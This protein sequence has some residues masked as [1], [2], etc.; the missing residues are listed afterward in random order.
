M[1]T[2][3]KIILVSIT[4]AVL[5]ILFYPV[6]RKPNLDGNW[7][8]DKLV[9]DDKVSRHEGTLT[10]SNNLVTIYRSN[11]LSGLI[12]GKLSFKDDSLLVKIDKIINPLS[13]KQID[14]SGKYKIDISKD[15]EGSG[16]RSVFVYQVT[17][18]SNNKKIILSRTRNVRWKKRAQRGMP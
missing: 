17:L 14:F 1:G 2:T 6:K 11:Y 12:T 15:V 3:K 10:I 18:S 9:I 13:S 16:E 5:V 4:I 7:S 8:I